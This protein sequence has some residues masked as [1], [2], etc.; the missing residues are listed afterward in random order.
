MGNFDKSNYIVNTGIIEQ[1]FQCTTKMI[2]LAKMIKLWTFYEN[3]VQ[4][5]AGRR[6]VLHGRQRLQR[7][8]AVSDERRDLRK[9]PAAVGGD[10]HDDRRVHS[11]EASQQQARGGAGFRP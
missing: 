10:E 7:P 2:L 6:R 11:R 4:A 8:H 5:C 9:F 1:F 3:V